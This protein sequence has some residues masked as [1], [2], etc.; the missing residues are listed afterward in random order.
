MSEKGVTIIACM[1]FS[2]VIL[3]ITML[4]SL[5]VVYSFSLFGIKDALT[6]FLVSNII[7]NTIFF[8]FI[9][10]SIYSGYERIKDEYELEC[11]CN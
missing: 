2:I 7:L 3:I 8:G 9:I 4:M 1:I 10:A 6:V 5:G 11:G